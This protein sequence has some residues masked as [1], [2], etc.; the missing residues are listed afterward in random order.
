M[1]RHPLLL[2][3]APRPRVLF[4]LLFA[5]ACAVAL[6]GSTSCASDEVLAYDEAPDAA[7]TVPEAGTSSADAAATCGNGILD[8]GEGCDDHNTVD[9]DGCSSKC[10]VEG[11]PPS[12]CPGTKLA[13]ASPTPESRAATVKGDT[14]SALATLDSPSCGGGNGKELVYALTSDV[15]GRA[16]VVLDAAFDA[17]LYARTS[18]ATATSELAC[19]NVPAGGGKTELVFPIDA[20]QTVYLVVDGAAGTSGK[21]QL[22]VTIGGASC[23][24]GLAQYPEQCD[25]GN[26]VAGD[27]C[28]PTCDLETPSAEPG[29]CPGASY[30][31]VGSLAAPVK[32]S[33]AGDV[34]T[35]ASTAGSFGCGSGSSGKDQVYAITPTISGAITAELVASYPSSLVHVRG[36]CFT[37]STELDCREE[38]LPSVP[39]KTTFPVVAQQTY[40]VFVDSQKSSVAD[41]RYTLDVTLS[42]PKCG[43]G[44]L[45]T[46]EACDDGNLDGGDGCAADCT[47]EAPP[48]GIDT[49]P[50][51]A[52]ALAGPAEGPMTF[53][54]TAS[55]SSLSASVKS[56]TNTKERKDAVYTFVAPY[57]GY[58]TAKAKGDF[59]TVLDL[60]TACVLESASTTAG[61]VACGR[62]DGGDGEESIAA[63]VTAGTT[64]YLVVEGS[65]TNANK[66]GVF[67]L[68][69]SIAKSVCGNGVIEG[70]EECD[71]GANAA[72]DGCA[73]DCALEPTPTSRTTCANAEALALTETAPGVY[74]A[75]ATGG[76]WNLPGGGYFTAPCAGAG[77]EAYFTVTPPIDGVVVARVDANYDISIGARPA[78][79]P[80]TSSGFLT[81]SNKSAGPGGE[82]I[83]YATAAGTKT[84]IIVDA[85]RVAEKGS[86]TIEVTVQGES[87]GDGVVS[88]AETCDDGNTKAGDGC[89]P[90][91]TLEPLAGADTCPGHAVALA[92]AGTETRSAV[93]S[94]STAALANDYGGTC[95][96]SGRDGVVAVTSDIAG[97]LTAQLDG[98]WP[99]VF[100]ARETCADSSSELDCDAYAANKPNETTRELTAPVFPGVPVYL[101]VDGIG[102]GSGPATLSLTV[103]P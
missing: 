11:A 85:P 90:T 21:F 91:C 81:C 51:A 73:P 16:R 45:E 79:P 8:P 23:G 60:R 53:H 82:V 37:S 55:T 65:N 98:A 103:T 57:D 72:G 30:T 27:G 34:S 75:T 42:P 39:V 100:Y 32:V 69:L 74:S 19:K 33:F 97:T 9:G 50:G 80:N 61:S 63:P 76:N 102:S 94:L 48:A 35:L 22:D 6:G 77:K 95:G 86:F 38:D 43:N 2:A 5:G 44:V 13:L 25:D 3:D 18:C 88:G 28:S 40:F 54:T 26:V 89:S 20:G 56:C 46:P 15:K 66:E 4:S 47:L 58:L 64:Y 49:C 62:A 36:E 68:D 59:N 17:L 96:G 67:S 31:L 92:G 84:W 29:V 101:F 41:G 52:I 7:V 71:D 24:D 93:V 70:G 83:S 87:C 14:S 12:A 99:T 78:C 1:K 10:I